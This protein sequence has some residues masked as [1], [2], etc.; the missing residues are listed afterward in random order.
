MT[1]PTRPIDATLRALR[2]IHGVLLFS[3]VLYVV[4]T[5]KIIQHQTG[6][7]NPQAQLDAV[8]SVYPAYPSC[9]RSLRGSKRGSSDGQERAVRTPLISLGPALV[10]HSLCRGQEN[11]R[12]TSQRSKSEILDKT[13]GSF[14][15]ATQVPTSR[16]LRPVATYALS[17]DHFEDRYTDLPRNFPSEEPT[18]SAC[19]DWLSDLRRISRPSA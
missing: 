17:C 7:L 18:A 11:A 1:Q 14:V 4:A 3:M 10:A 19:W 12:C 5:E 16:P 13:F 9:I 15:S 6:H 2:I 8:R